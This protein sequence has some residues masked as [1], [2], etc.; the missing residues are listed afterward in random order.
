[1]M[2]KLQSIRW[3]ITSLCN[4]NCKHC[5]VSDKPK[6]NDLDLNDLKKIAD[7]LYELG[8]K[9]ISFTSKEPLIH[10]NI[11]EL[12]KYCSL[13]G[14]ST[15]M[16]CNGT[17]LDSKEKVFN[18]I[19]AGLSLIGFS[20]EGITSSS[21]DYIRGNGVLQKVL[22]ALELIDQVKREHE[23][24]LNVVIQLSLNSLSILE[25]DDTIDFF[26]KLPIDSLS[27][28]DI[29]ID[30]N[31]EKH[32]Y[33]KLDRNEFI[34]ANEKL[35]EK[36]QSLLNR[37]FEFIPKEMVGYGYIYYNLK[38]NSEMEILT[39]NCSV[40]QNVFSI[41]SNGNIVSCI[42][43]YDE[44]NIQDC[45]LGNMMDLSSIDLHKIEEYKSNLKKFIKS[46]QTECEQCDFF[47]ECFPC[48]IKFVNK[49]YND[50][51]EQCYGFKNK[52]KE[53]LHTIEYNYKNY[54][55]SF[56]KGVYLQNRNL[57]LIICKL[58]KSNNVKKT[59]NKFNFSDK[60]IIEK[61]YSSSNGISLIALI[62]YSGKNIKEI[63]CLLERLVM[64]DFIRFE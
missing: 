2:I 50:I 35:V 12:M 10:H 43:L 56:A 5:F 14:M 33:L 62:N 1:M 36:Y 60:K 31:A 63:M 26:N 25:T 45:D 44:K 64:E 3:E 29:L 48:P 53:Y 20:L 7:N 8:V 11:T 47:Q 28:G 55:V 30:G 51:R 46:N 61:I 32:S 13:K 19:N 17:L 57:D 16:L 27:V 21:N 24:K 22:N 39:P 34:E 37:N 52:I 58:Y 40:F 4:L 38:Y 6:L 54:I 42:T 18:L 23:I 41:L 9:N 59:K 49:E 15:M